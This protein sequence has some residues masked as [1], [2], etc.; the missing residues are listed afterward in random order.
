MSVYTV[1]V[2]YSWLNHFIKLSSRNKEKILCLTLKHSTESRSAV[3]NCLWV[4]WQIPC[5]NSLCSPCFPYYPISQLLPNIPSCIHTISSY[6]TFNSWFHPS[7]H[8][9]A[10]VCIPDF[11]PQTPSPYSLVENLPIDQLQI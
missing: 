1:Y 10:S 3:K 9:N 7:F 11:I 4:E 8:P 5:S 6:A 2:W